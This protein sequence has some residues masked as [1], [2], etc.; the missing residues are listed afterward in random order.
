MFDA[1]HNGPNK[2]IKV[3]DEL[4]VSDHCYLDCS[5]GLTIGHGVTISEGVSVF[6]HEHDLAG[7]G[8]WRENPINYHPIEICG[9]AWIGAGAKIM[10][11]VKRIGN[12]AVVAAGAIVTKDV[13]D[14][15]IVAGNPAK[16][17]GRRHE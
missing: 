2:G 17:I 7:I 16:S 1:P 6:T 14:N 4:H 3:G 13:L 11:S 10:P 8:S 15:E 12:G 5:G 9:N